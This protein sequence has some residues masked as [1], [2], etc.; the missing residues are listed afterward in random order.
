MKPFRA[1]TFAGIGLIGFG[2]QL[3]TLALLV[4]AGWPYL[5]ATCVAVEAAVLHNFAWHERWT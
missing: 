2:V 5:V 4:L 3:A 1:A